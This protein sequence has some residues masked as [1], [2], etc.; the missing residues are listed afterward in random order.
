MFSW[1]KK[2][3]SKEEKDYESDD[4]IEE[5]NLSSEIFGELIDDI[6]GKHNVK[7]YRGK[8]EKILDNIKD[9]PYNR[10]ITDSHV[11]K[12]K[13]GILKDRCLP[14]PLKI[15]RD[16]YDRL[17]LLDGHHRK[18]ALDQIS[19]EN[20]DFHI[21]IR[22]ELYEVD[23]IKGEDCKELYRKSNSILPFEENDLPQ[24]II[25][26]TI[27]KLKSY[28]PNLIKL[29][30][31]NSVTRPFVDEN[32][33]YNGIRDSKLGEDGKLDADDIKNII[34]N[35]NN[36]LSEQE[37]EYFDSDITDKMFES[38]TDKEFFLGLKTKRN[39]DY[40]WFDKLKEF[41]K[42]YKKPKSKT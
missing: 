3:S 12:I 17:F 7:L 26:G 22:I 8:Y 20:K 1:G 42:K 38:A 29:K 25:S 14:T 13:S 24:L 21:T 32:L 30:G 36:W 40:D 15:A 2:S 18:K 9:L 16:K 27:T 10:K 4:D 31:K 34:I 5:E 28:Y 11:K 23:D 41:A 35:I 37:Q 39:G 33:I 19:K 6:G